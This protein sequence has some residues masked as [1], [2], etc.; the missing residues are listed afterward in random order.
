MS[1]AVYQ[2]QDECQTPSTVILLNFLQN[3]ILLMSLIRTP[4]RLVIPLLMR[5]ELLARQASGNDPIPA[6]LRTHPVHI[7]RVPNSAAPAHPRRPHPPAR[8][9]WPH[10]HFG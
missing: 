7:E 1:G 9:L 2:V 4:D 8:R 10:L 6:A 3:L 5:R